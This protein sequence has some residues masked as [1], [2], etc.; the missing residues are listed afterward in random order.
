MR[1]SHK[2]YVGGQEMKRKIGI[3]FVML[4]A[5]LLTSHSFAEKSDVVGDF[6]ANVEILH[7]VAVELETISIDVASNGCTKKEDF[8]FLVRKHCRPA[9]PE[10]TVIRINPDLCEG[11]THNIT[12]EFFRKDVWTWQG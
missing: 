3:F 11:F 9:A 1:V 12:L 6:R 5:C 7:G 2:T 8:I 10:V 4:L